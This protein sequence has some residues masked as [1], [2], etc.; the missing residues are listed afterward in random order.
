MEVSG[1]RVNVGVIDFT[2]QHR[3][4]DGGKPRGAPSADQGVT[5][6][7]AAQV[8]GKE[9]E[10]LRFDCFDQMPHYHY[11]PEKKNEQL[12]L[13][14]TT[15]G[16]PIGWAMNQLRTKL[17]EMIQ[18][19]GYEDVAAQLDASLLASKLN[20][21]EAMA[22]EAAAKE[23]DTVT[24]NKGEV[25]VDAGVIRFGLEFRVVPGFDTVG[26]AIHVLGNV[27]GEEIELLAFDCFDKNAHYHY[28]P[29]NQNLR[30]FWDQT[31]VPDTLAWTLDQFRAGRLSDMLARAGYPGI[32]AELDNDLV[33][34]KLPEIE[35][36]AQAMRNAAMAAA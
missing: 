22:R 14:T 15:A 9:A 5:I 13:D 7:V 33:R 36:K 4:L 2:V 29:R 3:Y 6:Q 11:G 17:P 16:N 34:T 8:D 32:A 27:S 31:V 35:A 28:G 21:V 26:Q 1:N 23:R 20:E 25:I 10:L 12:F 30:V 19:A 18:R 24:H